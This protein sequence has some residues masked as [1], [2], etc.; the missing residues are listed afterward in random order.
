[1]ATLRSPAV[2]LVTGVG[3]GTMGEGV[4][5]ELASMG[6]SIA[7]VEHPLRRAEAEAVV[8]RLRLEHGATA[9]ALTA[10]AT[11]P[12]EVDAAFAA[13]TAALGAAPNIVV[14][15]VGGGGVSADG[16][17]VNG[18]TNTDGTKR[19]EMAHEEDLQ[20]TARI[21][22]VTQLS[23]HYCAKAAARHMLAGGSDRLRARGGGAIVLVGSIMADFSAP[24]SAT[25]ASSKCA[26]RKLGEVMARELGPLGIRVNVLQPGHMATAVER[27]A[28]FAAGAAERT[29]GARI[30]L[31]RMGTAADIGKAAAFLCSDAAA[32]VTGATLNVDG[33]YTVAL[34]LQAAGS[35]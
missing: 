2:A 7:A 5:L 12:Q 17:P 14:S 34:D 9:V 33:G 10:D 26:V 6:C 11:A 19:T 25:Y 30:P 3:P 1:M 18:G 31:G 32:Y 23:Q 8:G 15:C 4:A 24:T 21:I 20:T 35:A 29:Q 16:Q 13:A 28:G 27:S 22:A